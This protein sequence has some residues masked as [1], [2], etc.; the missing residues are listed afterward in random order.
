M[1][2]LLFGL[3]LV[4]AC[5]RDRPA[6]PA[7]PASVHIRRTSPVIGERY[8]YSVRDDL[9]FVL[10]DG[11][12]T[13]DA[14]EQTDAQA[15]EIITAVRGEIATER[16]IRFIAFHHKPLAADTPLVAPVV[17]KTYRLRAGGELDG[18]VT[19]DERVAIKAYA[20]RDTGEP[21]LATHLFT[22]RDFERGVPWN[23]PPDHPAPF[24]RGTHEGASITLTEIDQSLVRFAVT[25][26]MVVE[27]AGQRVPITLNGSVVMD[28]GAARILSIDVEGHIT[29]RTGPV[30]EAHM[31]SRQTFTYPR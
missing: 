12:R 21:D 13:L 2:L 20:R 16:T 18:V 23:I 7:P 31:T 1:R 29:E 11:T 28:I 4:V 22:N 14:T 30:Q 19:D 6:A 8:T 9:K 24:A 10:T 17:G 26:V 15:E 27:P 25:Q 3:A 5:K